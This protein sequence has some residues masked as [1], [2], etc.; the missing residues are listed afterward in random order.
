[1]L[2]VGTGEDGDAEG[3]QGGRGGNGQPRVEKVEWKRLLVETKNESL[4]EQRKQRSG[5]GKHDIYGAKPFCGRK[6]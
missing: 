4:R 3:W 6:R 1:M 2:A 5:N